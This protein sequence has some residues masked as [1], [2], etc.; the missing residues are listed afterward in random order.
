LIKTGQIFILTNIQHEIG[1]LKLHS[2]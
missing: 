2:T 1:N